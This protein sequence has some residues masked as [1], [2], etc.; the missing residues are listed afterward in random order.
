MSK[1]LIQ[2]TSI[3][4]T[5]EGWAEFK[6]WLNGTY[7]YLPFIYAESATSYTIAAIDST[8]TRTFSINKIDATEFE[9]GYKAMAN[10]SL[11]PLTADYR[12]RVALEK[13]S[14]SR[15][16]QITFNWCDKTS[17]YPD[18][19]RIVDETPTEPENEAYYQLAH[20]YLIDT[21]HGKIFGEDFL[22]D[23]NNNSYRVVVKVDGVTKTEQNPHTG[24][25]GDYTIDYV[26]GRITPLSWSRGTGAVTVTYNYAQTSKFWVKPPTGCKLVVNAVEVQFAGNLDLTDT[27]IFQPRGLASYWAPQYGLPAGTKIPLGNPLMYKTI[28]NFYDDAMKS[29]PPYTALGGNSWRGSQQAMI[30]LDWD[31]TRTTDLYD[32]KGMDIEVRLEHDAAYGGEF[33]TV[34][35]YCDSTPE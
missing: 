12:Q 22:K 1:L 25:G 16:T 31:Y 21:Y 2:G 4:Y 15:A 5:E 6:K 14:G 23:A 13:P 19:A 34:T 10:K 35:F 27:A 26:N 24:S 7:A 30:L 9:A 11:V 29:Y 18:A 33:A 28:R 32:S 3:D 8:I 20:T 17:W